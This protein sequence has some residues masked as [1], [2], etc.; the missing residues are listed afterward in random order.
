M[1]KFLNGELVQA[2][3]PS[4]SVPASAYAVLVLDPELVEDARVYATLSQPENL[5]S[6]AVFALEW[7]A[8]EFA[9]HASASRW[10]KDTVYSVV[11][12]SLTLV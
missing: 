9:K 6:L 12:V 5:D 7:E 1:K 8:E 3:T 4:Y 10:G 11:P 2:S